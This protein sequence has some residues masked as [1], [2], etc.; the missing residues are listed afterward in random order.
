DWEL[1]AQNEPFLDLAQLGIWICRNRGEREE[2]LHKYLQQAPEPIQNRRMQLARLQ[3][4]SFYASAFHLVTRLQGRQ[5]I[6]AG[7]DLDDLFAEMARSG[8]PFTPE[9][10]ALALVQELQRELE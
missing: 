9:A 4:L 10:M 7:A 5:L 1:A 3:A 2:L 6:Q 8:Q